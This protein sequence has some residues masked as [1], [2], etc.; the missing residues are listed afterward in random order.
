MEVPSA[1]RLKP[2]SEAETTNWSPVALPLLN[3]LIVMFGKTLRLNKL[4]APIL[5]PAHVPAG[6]S[7]LLST[8]LKFAV[9][10]SPTPIFTLV[11]WVALVRFSLP[12]MED[13][14]QSPERLSEPDTAN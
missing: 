14:R 4:L 9:H 6:Y 2:K 8:T 13:K 1:N 5:K 3:V 7:L 11:I 10:P 12:D